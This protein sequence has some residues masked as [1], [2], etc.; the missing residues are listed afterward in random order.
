[1]SDGS[2]FHQGLEFCGGN[3][4]EVFRGC[5]FFPICIS[6][7]QMF[8]SM[9]F[10]G[11]FKGR[12]RTFP[13]STGGMGGTHLSLKAIRYTEG[14]LWLSLSMGLVRGFVPS[15][16]YG[17]VVLAYSL[18]DFICDCKPIKICGKSSSSP[19][20]RIWDLFHLDSVG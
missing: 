7:A 10:A 19:L 3:F 4:D 15:K 2:S 16:V 8:K 9:G 13:S 6:T 1:M 18:W 14:I 12:R 5:Y 11:I 17:S 20:S